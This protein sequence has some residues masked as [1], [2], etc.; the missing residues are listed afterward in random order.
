MAWTTPKTWNVGESL[1]AADL[2]EQL[3]DNMELLKSPQSKHR[4]PNDTTDYTTSN[5]AFVPIDN[6]NLA[7][8]ITP[9][10]GDVLA[11]FHAYV[12]ATNE[13]AFFDIEVNGV[14]VGGDEGITAA[15]GRTPIA[16]TRLI[17][18]VSGATTFKLMWKSASGGQCKIMR[19]STTFDL[20]PQ[21]WVR[22]VS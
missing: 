2:N 20:R 5:Q 6:A 18:N 14:R 21:F 4:E 10:G 7:L 8:Q 15:V 17:P 9:N 11:H 16:F 19:S 3:R 1:T 13:T 12:D 22:E